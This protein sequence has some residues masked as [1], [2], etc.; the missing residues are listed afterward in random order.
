MDVYKTEEEQLESIK[1]WFKING[2]G[3]AVVIIAVVG[4]FGGRAYWQGYQQT[5]NET[6]YEAFENVNQLRDAA[7]S[8][9][10]ELTAFKLYVSGVDDLKAQ[11]PKHALTGLAV[12]K[13]AADFAD[14]G[15]WD[16]AETELRWLTDQ[17]VAPALQ[18]LVAYRLAQ[19]LFQKEQYDQALTII[20]NAI[21]QD[22][23]YLPRL[24]E[25]QGDIYIEQDQPNKALKAYKDAATSNSEKGL[26]SPALQWKID[27]LAG[28]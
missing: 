3:I 20:T 17:K 10:A 22:D 7:L 16:A 23:D 18:S 1:K 19:V 9:N 25:L 13:V 5:H 4:F 15:E 24:Q 2:I 11:K 8:D 21:D 12:L 27:D 26:T 28:A 14:K 6:A